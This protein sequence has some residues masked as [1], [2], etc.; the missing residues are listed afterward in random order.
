MI[1]PDPAHIAVGQANLALN[2]VRA[3]FVQGFL[4]K[5][6]GAVRPF[7]TEES[8]MLELR[9]VDLCALF[10][11]RGIEHLTIL[12]CDAQGAELSVLEQVA[13]LLRARRVD[14]LFV[15]THHHAIS[16]DPLTHQRCLALLRSLGAQ[17]EVEHDVQESFSGDGLICARFA[18]APAGWRAH[19]S[20]TIGRASPCS[21][22]R[23]TISHWL[24]GASS[25]RHPGHD[26]DA[27][28][29]AR[30]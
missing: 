13:P 30:D 28:R 6:P 23:S 25:A 11:E 9:C 24:A 19:R 7:P 17:I 21:V 18:A 3:E 5:E 14:W 8:G 2:A 12:H 20:A 4:G 26:R 27:R 16:G 22:I 10:A 1:E 15:S 29:P